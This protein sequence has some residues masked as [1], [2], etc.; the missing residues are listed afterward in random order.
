MWKTW[1][2]FLKYSKGVPWWLCKT[3][4]KRVLSHHFREH[5]AH[6]HDFLLR[7]LWNC[8]C[9]RVVS[10]AKKRVCTCGTKYLLLQNFSTIFLFL[11]ELEVVCLMRVTFLSIT[12]LQCADKLTGGPVF[13]SISPDDRKGYQLKNCYNC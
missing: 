5:S 3:W 6:V 1:T 7:Y 13:I 9:E 2:L 11:V 4:Y 12:L 10:L 8:F